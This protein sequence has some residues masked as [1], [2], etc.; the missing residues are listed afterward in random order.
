MASKKTIR[1]LMLM[2]FGNN[3]PFGPGHRA[4][5][6]EIAE[7][8]IRATRKTWELSFDDVPDDALQHA[9][10]AF[11][12]SPEKKKTWPDPGRLR[13]LLPGAAESLVDDADLMWGQLFQGLRTGRG[14]GVPV[15]RA[16]WEHYRESGNER[17]AALYGPAWTWSGTDAQIAAAN[18]ALEALGGMRRM[19]DPSTW[20]NN[21]AEGQLRHSFRA[22]YRAALSQSRTTA[23]DQRV[24]SLI[25]RGQL[26]F[27]EG[28]DG[29]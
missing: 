10:V 21:A 20:S 16:L 19:N 28:T 3:I 1:E 7:A 8:E 5:T 25:G 22:A 14:P 24:A 12:N 9:V 4:S 27:L 26:R 2:L 13:M 6:H 18:R 29:E 17:A 15:D 11:L 23:E